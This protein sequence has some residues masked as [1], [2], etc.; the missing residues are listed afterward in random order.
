MAR[1]RFGT[2]GLR[3]VANGDLTAEL[4]VALGR[5]AARVLDAPTFLVGRDT[6]RSGPFLQAALS[7]GLAAE[8]ADVVDLGVLPTPGVAY[9]AERQKLPAAVVSASHNPFGDN[10]IKLFGHGGAK[11]S[12]EVEAAVE[13]R[14][15]GLLGVS[16]AGPTG[17]GV[18][19]VAADPDAVAG[20]R[21]HLVD[22]LAGRRLDGLRVVLDCANGAASDVAPAVFAAL[23]ADVSTVGC[24]PDG[25]NINDGCGSTHPDGLAAAVPAAGADLGLAFDGDADRVV[26]VDH[27]GSVVHG[28]RLVAM[29]AVDLASRGELTADTVVV[30]AMT[31]L[32]FRLGMAERGIAV[33]ETAVGDRHV[34]MALDAEGLA[35]GGEQ[36]GHIVFRHRATT[37]DGVLSGLL[38]ADLVVRSGRT[39]AALADGLMEVLPQVLVNVPV[40]HPG[41]LADAEAVWT[42]V[43]EA[44]ARLGGTGRVLLRPSG[45]EPLVRVMVEAATED[46]A[47]AAAKSLAQVVERA[48][49]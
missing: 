38:L 40:A 13:A 35:L 33:R 20:Y 34:L 7:A 48:L 6:R 14:I 12:P 49:R 42:A 24:H 2:D 8:G 46:D 16:V 4:A 31:N 17:R 22:Q 18:G 43:R 47:A 32:G 25:V 41:R 44:E 11:L 23:G 9:C 21:A 19:T 30:T 37:G 39:V 36:S 5:A 27:T 15:D 28:D 10:G 29:F 45:T 26:A 1:A 3:G